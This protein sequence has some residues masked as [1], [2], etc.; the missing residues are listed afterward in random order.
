M[1]EQPR[2]CGKAWLP[3]VGVYACTRRSTVKRDGK[4]YCWQHDPVAVEAR[5]AKAQAKFD[6]KMA[7]LE[8]GHDLESAADDL[9]AACEN[10]LALLVKMGGAKGGTADEMRA[11]IAKAKGEGE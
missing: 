6:H 2:C 10:G 4:M 7:H 11:A 1:R 5:R 3:R 8:K 9:L